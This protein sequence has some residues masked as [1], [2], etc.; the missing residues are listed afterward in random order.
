MR[1]PAVVTETSGR[2]PETFSAAV[3]TAVEA[4]AELL[5]R[6]KGKRD[7]SWTEALSHNTADTAF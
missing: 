2:P 6:F 4:S 7:A 3:F 5:G 1:W